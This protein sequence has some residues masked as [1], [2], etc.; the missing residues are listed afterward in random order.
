MF[1][2]PDLHIGAVLGL[3]E[4][5]YG[6]VVFIVSVWTGKAWWSRLWFS[7]WGTIPYADALEQTP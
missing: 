5:D 4:W 2:L 7:A 3:I 6:E 1:V